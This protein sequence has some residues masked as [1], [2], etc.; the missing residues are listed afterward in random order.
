MKDQEGAASEAHAGATAR[1]DADNARGTR[2]LGQVILKLRKLERQP[3]RFG[4]AGLL[5]PSEIHTI[6]AIGCGR[7]VL[8]S[9]LAA[10]LQVTK[11]AVTQLIARL[12]A[13][14]LVRRTPH[15]ADSR[16][17]ELV[18]T[19]LGIVA[20]EAHEETQRQFYEELREVLTEDEIA[21]FEISM[22]KLSR[23]LDRDAHNG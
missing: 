2:Y 23:F 5:T 13:K 11:G 20:Y 1:Q 15:P 14:G 10:R 18:L 6:E 8:M 7:G 9:E 4:S 19:E 17:T 3:R 16:A 12:E 21:V 22:Q